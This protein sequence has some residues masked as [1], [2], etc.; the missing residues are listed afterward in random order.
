VIDTQD[1]F[2]FINHYVQHCRSHNLPVN[3]ALFR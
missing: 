2:W 3:D 1:V